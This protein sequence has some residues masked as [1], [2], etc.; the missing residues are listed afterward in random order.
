MF[1]CWYK[2]FASTDRQA[3]RWISYLKRTQMDMLSARRW[4]TPIIHTSNDESVMMGAV[5]S[6]LRITYVLKAVF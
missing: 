1:S 5:E 2:N 4:E 6:L 3:S